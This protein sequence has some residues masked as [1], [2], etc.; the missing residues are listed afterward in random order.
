MVNDPLYSN[1]EFEQ[2]S[3]FAKKNNIILM[4][5]FPALVKVGATFGISPDYSKIGVLTGQIANRI[6]MKTSTCGEER[7]ILPDQSSFS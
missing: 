4:T 5:S 6:N 2:L 3:E 1:V 7:V